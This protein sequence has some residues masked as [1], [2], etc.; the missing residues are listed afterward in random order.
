MSIKGCCEKR[1]GEA[2]EDIFELVP[3][4]SNGGWQVKLQ[5]GAEAALPDADDYMEREMKEQDLLPPRIENP[6]SQRLAW[7]LEGRLGAVRMGERPEKGLK[8]AV[9]LHFLPFSMARRAS[10]EV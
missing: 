10:S 5:P 7:R 4:G 2:Y 3:D 9:F 6:R 1:N 8:R